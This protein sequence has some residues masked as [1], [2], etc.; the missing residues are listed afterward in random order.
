MSTRS[1]SIL[2]A[3][4]LAAAVAL[5]AGEAEPAGKPGK[6]P[7]ASSEDI[8][9]ERKANDLYNKGVE[10]L[11][12]SSTE[13]QG[14]KRLQS[15]PQLYPKSKV[16]FKAWMALGRL[17]IDKR[18]YDLAIKQFAQIE[19]SED[20]EELAEALYRTG[21]CH[22]SSNDYEKAFTSL[23]KVTN[24]YPW[25]I[26]ANEAFY[27]IGQCHFKLRRWTNAVEALEMVG[28][29]VPLSQQADARAEAGQRLFIKLH[30]KDLVVLLKQGQLPTARL[31]SSNGDSATVKLDPIGRDGDYFLGSIVTAPGKA[32]PG[33]DILE[34][35]G[36]TTVS[37]EYDDENTEDGKRHVKRMSKVSLVSTAAVGFTDGAYNEY[38]RGVYGDHDAFLRVRD[39]DR[40]TSDKPDVLTVKLTSQWTEKRV[41]DG[42]GIELDEQEEI[43]RQR[44]QIEV[45]LTET[46]SH[47]GVFTGG[48][49]VE[50]VQKDA[51]KAG[52]SGVIGACAG[53]DLVLAYADEINIG[54]EPREAKAAAKVLTGRIGDVVNL[55]RV[56]TDLDQKARKDLI[57]GK[58]LLKLAQIFR[59]VGLTNKATEKAD[60]GHARIEDVLRTSDKASLSREIVEEAYTVKWELF[61]AQDKLPEA[62]QVCNQ[63]IQRFPDS[64]LVDQALLKIGQAKL[65]AK[66]QEGALAVLHNILRMPKSACKAEAQFTIAQVEEERA[67]KFPNQLPGAMM[68]YKKV[69]D[70]YPDSP[71]AGEALDKIANFY[72]KTQD[73][74]RAI[75][76]LQQVTQDYEDAPFL[77][78][79]LY[80]WVIAAFRAGRFQMARDRLN[81]LLNRYPN[82][83]LAG[84]AK[85][86]AVQID[87]KL[88]DGGGN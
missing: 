75:E 11:A 55:N 69:A 72:I 31:T 34:A 66:E 78:R 51:R 43:V 32:V 84:S 14:I 76:L 15:V 80:K 70:N 8:Q 68:A 56:L 28:T 52:G 20:G 5:P 40:D 3:G 10:L 37:I 82:S 79:V 12:N 50:L 2:L 27:Y 25:S 19:A 54:G 59:E 83:P 39:L 81:E 53:D 17:Y 41:D 24:Q 23:R 6:R 4:L 63:L 58:L 71:F 49:K 18:N 36:G 35:V 13:E 86:F 64:T 16:R 45:R 33:N 1:I 22:F 46:D 44:D 65:A 57:E 29:S 42:K 21:I 60:L 74:D 61:I 9:A 88:G 87:R 48:V 85:E 47:S 77:D 62:I 73:Y 30:D 38:V 26:Y 67:A 7:T